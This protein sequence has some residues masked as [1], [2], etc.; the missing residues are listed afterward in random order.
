MLKN[1]VILILVTAWAHVA[2]GKVVTCD[3]TANTLSQCIA[4]ATSSG[5]TAG[6][7]VLVPNSTTSV[8]SLSSTV[9]LP[10]NLALRCEPNATIQQNGASGALLMASGTQNI[11]LEGCIIDGSTGST[12]GLRLENVSGVRV[13]HNTFQNFHAEGLTGQGWTDVEIDSNMF[14]AVGPV[15]TN[16]SALYLFAQNGY[17]GST[18]IKVH[19]NTCNNL[20]QGSGCMKFAASQQKPVTQIDVTNNLLNVGSS[21]TAN[22]GIEF[23]PTDAKDTD[24]EQFTVSNNIVTT[25][26]GATNT[27]C[28]SISARFGVIANNTLSNCQQIGI[29]VIAS[30]TN[31]VGNTL[32]STGPIVWD[33]NS[34]PH[35]DVLI[36]SNTMVSSVGAAAIQVIAGTAYNLN[37]GTV[38]HNVI[39]APT[40]S[41]AGVLVQTISTGAVTDIH[42]DDN[43]FD[44]FASSQRA[45]DTEGSPAQVQ[46]E[47]NRFINVLGTGLFLNAGANLTIRLNYFNGTTWLTNN[48]ATITRSIENIVNGSCC[49]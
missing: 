45:V 48:G 7:V 30:Y 38:G 3:P 5:Q 14:S 32:T 8:F 28:I 42:I 22:L 49:F 24:F 29:E 36:T 12:P 11:A 16:D 21:A 13:S 6:T 1:V 2:Q 23:Y 35:E 18:R 40:G 19:H 37:T 9:S 47:N 31:V 44:A 34:A 33:G 20:T 46:I 25:N 26:A 17:S 4:S 41:T 10:S 39:R 15:G 27:S 43:M